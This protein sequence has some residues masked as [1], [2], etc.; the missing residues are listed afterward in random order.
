MD[1][2]FKGRIQ[3]VVRCFLLALV[4]V[5]LSGCDGPSSAAAG[6]PQVDV[7][8]ID[9]D[10]LV[11]DG[12]TIRLANIDAPEQGERARCWAEAALARQATEAAAKYVDDGTGLRVVDRQGRDQYGRSLARVVLANDDDLGETLISDGLAAK[13]TGHR[14]SWCS[15]PNLA[16]QNGPPLSMQAANDRALDPR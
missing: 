1:R 7:R 13:W 10:T 12:E 9:G 2:Q 11:V 15:T 5:L 16:D 4:S 8:V 3:S 14:W 6:E